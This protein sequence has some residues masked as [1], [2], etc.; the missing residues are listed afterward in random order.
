M[1]RRTVLSIITLAVILVLIILFFIFGGGKLFTPPAEEEMPDA[2][3]I[4]LYINEVVTSS[5]ASFFT[6]E[7]A[8]D[9]IELYNA[10]NG[11]LSLS[12]ISISDNKDNPQKY[13]FKNVTIPAH[14]YAVILCTG[15]DSEKDDGLLRTNFRLS[16]SGETL[17]LFNA[18]SLI[19]I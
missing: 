10:T 19:H 4:G 11:S 7:G 15:D 5:R 13:V 12:G 18:L 16:S 14:S 6:E 8:C 9:W 1:H 3:T 17:Y 2:S